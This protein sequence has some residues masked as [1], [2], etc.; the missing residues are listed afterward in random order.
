M[1]TR[2]ALPPLVA[3]LLL[4]PVFP[5][6]PVPVPMPGYHH[7]GATT[8]A[9][10]SG[11]LGRVTVRD[12]GVRQGTHDFVATRFLAKR[13]TDRGVAW[14]EAGWAETGWA[15]GGHQRV[16]TYDTNRRSWQFY[17]QYPVRD[18]DRIWFY[19]T[20]ENDRSWQAWLWWHDAW[21][22]LTE[23]ELPLTDRAQIEQYVEVYVDPDR[24]GS[25]PVPPVAV[26]NVQL[27]SGDGLRYWRDRRIGTLSG[28]SAGAFCLDWQ[29]RFD[30]WSAGTCPLRSP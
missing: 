30:T 28:N 5:T 9:P 17:D 14:L 25:Y 11:I 20:A 23:Q 27:R 22:L 19:L 6:A 26:D 29:T 4:T 18:G 2:Y 8:A 10:W 24:G 16:Y 7:L 12:P 15:G 1:R 13:D 21:H 3:A